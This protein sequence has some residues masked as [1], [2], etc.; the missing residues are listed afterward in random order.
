MTITVTQNA[1]PLEKWSNRDFLFYFSNKMQAFCGK[2]IAI[3]PV[4]WQ[5]MMGRMKGFRTKLVLDNLSYKRFI[6]AVFGEFF[7]QDGYIPHF[8]AIVSERVFYTVQ[9]LSHASVSSVPTD[10]EQLR[11]ELYSNNLLF[12]KLL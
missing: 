7:T 8:G 9:K 1:K 5:G 11:A 10:W 2:G 6:D 12:Q 3:P 4:A